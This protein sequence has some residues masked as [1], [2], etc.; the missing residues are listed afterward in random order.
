MTNVLSSPAPPDILAV[1]E[2]VQVK[3]GLGITA[4]QDWCAT[5]VHVARRTWQSWEYGDRAMQIGK[6]ELLLIKLTMHNVRI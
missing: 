2:T 3:L 5:Q 1:R 4:A 6:W